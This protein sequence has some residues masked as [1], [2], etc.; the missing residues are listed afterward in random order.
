MM[1]KVSR[2]RFLIWAVVLTVLF[3]G[4]VKAQENNVLIIYDSYN[5][6]GYEENKL[7]SLVQLV[8]DT[9]EGVDIVNITAYSEKILDKYKFVFVL[10][11]NSS[12]SVPSNLI[13]SLYAFKGKIMWIGKNFNTSLNSLTNVQYISGFSSENIT[14]ADFRKKIY[15][16]IKDKGWK[17]NN[18]YILVDK[19][20]PF[21]DLNDFVKKIDFL[22]DQGISF[23]CSVMP[24][25]ENHNFDAMKNFCQVLRYA[26]DRGGDIILHSSVI[27]GKNIPGK[28]VEAKMDL[29]QQIYINYGVYPRA[30]DIPEGFLYKKD[31][32]D[33][34][35]S[36]NN[37]FIE[38]DKDIGILDFNE[39][40]IAPFYRIINKV[41]ISDNYMCSNPEDAYN[42][43]FVLNSDLSVEEFKEKVKYIINRGFYFSDASYLDSV[44]KLGGV[45]LKYTG[46]DILLGDESTGKVNNNENARKAEDEIKTVDIGNLYSHIIKVTGVICIVFIIIIL[47]SRKIDIKKFFK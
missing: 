25:Y 28:D 13:K 46:Y 1:F 9:G 19:V 47:I 12:Q 14:Y 24:V 21:V 37:L 11:N 43:A 41:D 6:F 35:Y 33:L 4:K 17:E 42:I 32:K 26:K 22:Y 31:Y 2:I 15:I 16:F 20:Y 39:Y 27:Y 36:S 30:L 34:I 23:I 40:S 7:N 45:E 18:V 29:A 8:L 38:K 44:M 3:V 10:Y 5:E